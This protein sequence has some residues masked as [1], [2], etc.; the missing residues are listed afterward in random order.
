M[1]L[2]QCH[3]KAKH[4]TLPGCLH[5]DKA[6]YYKAETGSLLGQDHIYVTIKQDKIKM[7]PLPCQDKAMC[8]SEY[9]DPL[10]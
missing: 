8:T 9:T 5:Q 6:R 2:D 4:S 3:N 10:Y 7:R 1:S